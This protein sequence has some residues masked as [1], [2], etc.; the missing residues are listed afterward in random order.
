MAEPVLPIRARKGV[1]AGGE[2]AP[3]SQARPIITSAQLERVYNSYFG[4]IYGF[5][6]A[7]V[8]NKEDAEDLTSHVFMK[9]LQYLDPSAAPQ[10]IAAYL[11]QIARTEIA[12][13]WRRYA[14]LRVVPLD[15]EPAARQLETAGEEV[16]IPSLPTLA[17]EL[18]RI[19]GLLPPNYRRVLEL[20]FYEG[21]SIRETARAMNVSE[22]NAKVLQYRAIHR[23]AEYARETEIGP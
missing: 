9:S 13:H 5:V 12:D 17:G 19:L 11:Y 16:E 18:E 7:R 3:T 2:A 1:R 21:C 22:G 4:S 6:F 20:R 8:G 14:A 23:A 10:E 15:E